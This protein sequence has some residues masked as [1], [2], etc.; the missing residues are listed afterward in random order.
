VASLLSIQRRLFLRPVSIANK[1]V[2]HLRAIT[3]FK[4]RKIVSKNACSVRIAITKMVS[5]ASWL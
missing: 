4:D 5:V 3:R 1:V 2:I